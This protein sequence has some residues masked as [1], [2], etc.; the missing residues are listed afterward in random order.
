MAFGLK[1]INKYGQVT[2]VTTDNIARKRD[3]IGVPSY[4]SGSETYSDI[5]R[6]KTIVLSVGRDG[7]PGHKV[8]R[9][10]TTVTYTAQGNDSGIWVITY[11]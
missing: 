5:K 9:S 6:Q 4:Q 2:L 1:T 11:T 10:G 7:S 3:E 8:E